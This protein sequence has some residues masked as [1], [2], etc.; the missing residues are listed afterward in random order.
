MMKTI[1]ICTAIDDKKHM[2]DE[3]PPEKKHMKQLVMKHAIFILDGHRCGCLVFRFRMRKLF[4]E[5]SVAS[6]PANR[7]PGARPVTCLHA[8]LFVKSP[9]SFAPVLSRVAPLGNPAR[10][11]NAAPP[12]SMSGEQISEKP[13]GTTTQSRAGLLKT[14]LPLPVPPLGEGEQRAGF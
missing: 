1:P 14:F 10:F 9:L 3:S 5:K 4:C 12:R 11:R 7:A 13:G 6:D 8:A 2:K